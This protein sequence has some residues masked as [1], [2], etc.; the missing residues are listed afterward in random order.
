MGR[1]V[2]YARVSSREQ[3]LDRQLVALRDY[4]EE[5]MIVTDM[6]S[7]K[8]L[9]RPGYQSFKYGIGKLRA[10][11]ELY[12][13]SLDRLSRNKEDI[14]K[15]LEY[16]ASI[17]VRVKVIDIPTTMIDLPKGQEWV[18]E[19]V[20]N[21][22]FEVLASFAEQERVSIKQRQAEGI[23]AMRVV[24][25]KRISN[26]TG[27]PVG[28]PPLQYPS[29]WDEVYYMWKRGE[30]TAVKAMGILGMK[31]TSFYRLVKE[32]KQKDGQLKIVS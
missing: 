4:V 16:Y 30:I 18:V 9:N 17:G 11:D 5:D 20:N 29:N 21:I 24:N 2:G 1:K 10:G 3:N 13:K 14:K 7:G 25:G 27:N 32:Q 23:A 15:E 26:R 22:I 12:I 31:R 19:M 8:D 6:T 28:R